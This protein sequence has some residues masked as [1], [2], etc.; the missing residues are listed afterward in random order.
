MVDV[1]KRPL[2][3]FGRHPKGDT[4]HL[5]R[6]T[7]LT[8][9]LD[10]STVQKRLSIYNW[11]AGRGKGAFEKQ[12]EGKGHVITLQEA[13]ECRP[14]YFDKS[15]PRDP[16][17]SMRVALQQ[18]HPSTQILK[19]SLLHDTRREVPHKVMQGEQGWVM[20]GILTLA[21][22]P[23]TQR[24]ETFT[25]LSLHI[26][27]ICAIKWGISKKLILTIRA[28]MIGQHVDLVSGDFNGTAWRCS[29]RNST[30]TIEETFAGCALPTPPGPPPLWWPGSIPNNWADVCEF[31]KPLENRSVLESTTSL[32]VS[33]LLGLTLRP[34]AL[35][36]CCHQ[37]SLTRGRLAFEQEAVRA[38]SFQSP[39]LVLHV[40]SCGID[41]RQP[42]R[43]VS[44]RVTEIWRSCN[45][46][47]MFLGSPCHPL[48][49]SAPFFDHI[50]WVRLGVLEKKYCVMLRW[51]WILS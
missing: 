46:M 34:S 25:V 28:I 27:N 2:Q 41:F 37:D 29:N 26:S 8:N 11:K 1:Q 36:F 51:G 33:C 43:N 5:L 49:A 47:K 40:M 50:F 45:Y 23:T 14:W 16:L 9:V 19:S 15:L 4:I 12:I 35:F 6:F 44:S 30:S 38:S 39:R 7:A 48:Q 18:G 21:F 42:L 24:P 3:N 31:L 13:S 22:S 10:R 20:Q 32:D 17:R